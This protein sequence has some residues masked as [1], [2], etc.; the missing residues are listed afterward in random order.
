MA[1]PSVMLKTNK[2][3]VAYPT[4]TNVYRMLT[5]HP[6][7]HGVLRYNELRDADEYHPQAVIEGQ[8][9]VD[10]I[11]LSAVTDISDDL[12][13]RARMWLDS[14]QAWT[15]PP[16]KELVADAIES[17]CRAS[18]YHPV[19]C[20]LAP[21]VATWDGVAR[22]DT[23]LSDYCGAEDT[24]YVRAVASKMLMSACARVNQ[25]GCK[26]DTMTVFVGPQGSRKS[27]AVRVLGGEW[28]VDTPVEIG[29]KDSYETIR[30]GWIIEVPELAGL[31]G[32]DVERLKAFFSS[33][34]D[35]YRP[36]YGR[37][38]VHRKRSCIF[39]GTTNDQ[40]FLKDATGSRRF[41]CVRTGLIDLD[42]LARVRDQLW[43]EAC[44][45]YLQGEEWWFSG[46]LEEAAAEAA[47]AFVAVDPWEAV[48]RS[49]IELSG[50]S[51]L[52][53]N[54][55]YDILGIEVRDQ[56]AG[57]A[58]RIVRV[59]C[60]RLGWERPGSAF[61]KNGVRA[62]GFRVPI[63]TQRKGESS[64]HG[65]DSGGKSSVQEEGKEKNHSEQSSSNGGIDDF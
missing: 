11:G 48:M 28:T 29:S 59:F 50:A 18:T 22:V 57:T 23:W 20:W 8:A 64:V 16:G 55:I 38:V 32:K 46:A 15:G 49:S 40:D 13:F 25:P 7:W 4:A 37:K 44:L 65:G 6:A 2:D 54:E 35:S 9:G 53:T 21:L 24:P 27:S 51:A 19:T 39:A 1:K 3:G 63:S 42:G 62:R 45:R 36:P 60:G 14:A 56:H 5:H 58:Q 47:E 34:T 30:G 17:A 10:P 26:V 41:L 61:F 33:A 12:I 31:G 43:A 52:H